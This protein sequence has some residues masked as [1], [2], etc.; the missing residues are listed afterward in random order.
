MIRTPDT[1]RAARLAIDIPPDLFPRSVAIIMD[2]NGRWATAKKLPRSA[3]HEAGAMIVGKIVVEASQLGMEALSLYSFSSE[4]WARPADEIKTLM[5]IYAKY[6]ARERPL[7]MEHGVR[8]RHIGHREGLPEP[9]LRELD[10]SE[11]VTAD[12]PGMHLCM[13]LNYGSRVEITD[14]VKAIAADAVAGR[15]KPEQIDEQLISNSLNTAGV[16]DPDLLIRTSGE[17]RISNFLL[18]Q[19]SYAEFYAADAY[20][21]DFCNAEFHKAI[22]NYA[23]RHRRFGGLDQS[24]P[25]K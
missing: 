10:E 17:M 11:R 15:I 9:V 6:L 8:L 14:A 16:P 21:P 23:E 1:I 12:N 7:M 13:A 22:R 5:H 19:S 20:W 18:W 3:G 4:N 25:T 24:N 2:G